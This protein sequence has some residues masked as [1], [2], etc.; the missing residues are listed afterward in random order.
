MLMSFLNLKQRNC[1]KHC[2]PKGKDKKNPVWRSTFMPSCCTENILG[3][4][5]T[6]ANWTE[7]KIYNFLV[8]NSKGN[9]MA[10]YTIDRLNV[11]LQVQC[12]QYIR[13]CSL[14]RH[15]LYSLL[16]KTEMKTFW[17]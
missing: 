10:Y 5:Y 3:N 6:L 1:K 13:A 11:G 9:Y 12:L 4:G 16:K 8:T 17:L 15:F 7:S 14:Y 2:F